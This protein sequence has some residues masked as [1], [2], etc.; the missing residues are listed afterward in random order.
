MTPED[1]KVTIREALHEAVRELDNIRWDEIWEYVEIHN[2]SLSYY[3]KKYLRY[4]RDSIAD[5]MLTN[6]EN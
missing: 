6:E 3:S 4:V 5:A 1:K 2:P